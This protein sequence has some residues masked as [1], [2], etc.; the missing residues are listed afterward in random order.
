[1]SDE[2]HIQYVVGDVTIDLSDSRFDV[3]MLVHVIEHIDDVDH[4]LT[5]IH[6]IAPILI[7]EV[8]D[9]EADPLNT[10]R[11]TLGCPFYSDGDHLREYSLPMLRQQLERNGW[12]IQYQERRHASI[13]AVANHAT[14]G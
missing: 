7:I 12:S 9:F 11:H 5:A 1:M 6:K 10:A 13:L 14:T 4:L 2:Q 8:P 3:A